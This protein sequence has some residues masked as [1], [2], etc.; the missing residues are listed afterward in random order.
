MSVTFCDQ[1]V[2]IFEA[3]SDS[4]GATAHDHV[5]EDMAKV[6]YEKASFKTGVPFWC[7]S[8]MKALRLSNYVVVSSPQQQYE[9]TVEGR[10]AS[11]LQVEKNH[12]LEDV[13]Q[14]AQVSARA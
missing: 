13:G 7:A 12:Y 8:P 6:S 3:N 1:I 10:V 14:V 2:H 4:G 5:F 9:G 11:G